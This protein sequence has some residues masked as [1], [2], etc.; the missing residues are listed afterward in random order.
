MDLKKKI[1]VTKGVSMS[2]REPMYVLQSIDMADIDNSRKTT[3]SDLNP[4]Q[5]MEAKDKNEGKKSK[6]MTLKE[7]GSLEMVEMSWNEM[8]VPNIESTIVFE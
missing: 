7:D 5:E 1:Y 3:R 8:E 4:T 2:S 6:Q